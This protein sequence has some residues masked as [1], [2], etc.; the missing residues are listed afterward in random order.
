[1]KINYNKRDVTLVVEILKKA[2]PCF[3]LHHYVLINVFNT[4]TQTK[5][6]KRF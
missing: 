2:K 4:R 3:S 1:L 5:Y 6:F